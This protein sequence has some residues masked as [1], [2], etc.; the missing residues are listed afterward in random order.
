MG[1]IHPFFGELH[2]VNMQTGIIA[3]IIQKMFAE[4]LILEWK[5]FPSKL[6]LAYH[7]ILIIFFFFKLCKN[8]ILSICLHKYISKSQLKI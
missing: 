1:T 8:F 7:T 4:F 6:P 3:T 5:D 2:L